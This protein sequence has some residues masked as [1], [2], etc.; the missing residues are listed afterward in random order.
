[1]VVGDRTRETSTQILGARSRGRCL[2]V[3][4]LT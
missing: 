2:A 3:V 1:M 4:G